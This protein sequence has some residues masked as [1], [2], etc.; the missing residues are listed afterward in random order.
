MSVHAPTRDS[1]PPTASTDGGRY[2]RPQLV[3]QTWVDLDGAWD[4][5]YDDDDRGLAD[6]WSAGSWRSGDRRRTI[7]VPFPPE[8][9]ASGIGDT[10]FH[11]VC[12][13]ARTVGSAELPDPGS[14]AV[15]HFGAVDYRCTVWVDG[16]E[17]GAHEGGHT[18]FQVEL[19]AP[20]PD[21]E[22]QIVVRVEDDPADPS[23]PRGKQDWELEPHAVWYHRTT[24]IWQPVWLEPLPDVAVSAIHWTPDVPASKV[25]VEIALDRRPLPGSTARVTV[26]RGDVVLGRMSATA[27]DRDI[28][29]SVDLPRFR[30]AQDVQDLLWSPEN[31]ALLD[32]TVELIGPD[33]GVVDAAAS[34]FGMRSV[35]VDRSA[36]LLNDKPYY[37]RSVLSQ[38]YW[39][40]SH[41]AAPSADGLRAEAQAI[42]DL[43]F[44]AV[45]VHQKIEDP[46]FLYWA[47]RL[48][49]LVWVEMPSAYG[50][51]PLTAQRIV[52][53]WSEA[54]ARDRSHPSVVT[55]VPLNESW[56]VDRIAQDARAQAFADGLAQLT[57]A[58]DGSRPVIS[59]DGWE[60]MASDIWTVH[61]YEGDGDIVAARYR[62]AAAL[63]PLFAGIGPAGRRISLVGTSV[64]EG[65]VMLTEFG[66]IKF[67]SEAPGVDDDSWGYT[68]ASTAGD[69]QARLADVMGGAA[70]SS[71]LA[72]VC[73][74]QLTDTLQEKNGLLD[75]HRRPKLPIETLRSL[76]ETL[77]AR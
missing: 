60:H 48:G 76:I 41:L 9:S 56:G 27:D 74:T 40:E 38:G 53:E 57:R 37:V 75:E 61:D 20:G 45:R 65:P 26:T 5:A 21:A 49:L 73:Y 33:G 55:W 2:P 50:F 66:G 46:R 39:P 36:F 15:L 71:V 17:V 10:G 7:Q 28:R 62:D 59:N 51:S 25:D 4:F 30:N 72:G 18:P 47:D 14:R 54:V 13:Y 69:F 67:A 70:A 1:I 11:P 63:V 19:G 43:G 44:T 29:A 23:Q 24:G 3:R 35:A 52:S 68:E 64:P 12:W 16:R 77:G 22:W 31:P 34:Y 6:G 8:S 32:A 58:L 42:K